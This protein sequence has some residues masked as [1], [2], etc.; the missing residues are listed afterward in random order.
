MPDR[1]DDGHLIDVNGRTV[2][3]FIRR[4]AAGRSEVWSA[5]TDPE[6][7][8]R[9]AFQVE[10]E[11][12]AGGSLRFFYGEHGTADGTIIAWD[13]PDLLEYE[14]GEGDEA[15]HVR[16]ELADDAAG[17]TALT[18]DHYLP[19]AARP[20]FAAGWHWHLDRLAIVVEGDTP[21]PV[22]TD[23]HFD[24]LLAKYQQRAGD[25]ATGD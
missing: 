17:G 25:G 14:W 9:W 12:R 13:E 7:V 10:F 24:E 18:F 3:R 2:V 6:R 8:A 5:I 1:T 19:D 21:P 23:A 16:F 20:E 22:D 4:Y 11:P 15:W